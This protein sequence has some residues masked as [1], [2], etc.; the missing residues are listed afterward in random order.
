MNIE[1]TV[2]I[3]TRSEAETEALGMTLARLLRPGSVVALRGD[4]A[5]GKTCLVRGMARA[6]TGDAAVHSPTFT[7]VN[8]YGSPPALYHF[9]LYRLRGPEELFALGYEERFG[10]TAMAAVEWAERAEP[11]LPAHRVEIAMRHAGGDIREIRI[12]DLGCL[13]EGWQ[14]ALDKHS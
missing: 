9:D 3:T 1:R 7:L 6:L 11:L 4:L 13:P 8:E 14:T 12:R 2:Q 10:G 5:A